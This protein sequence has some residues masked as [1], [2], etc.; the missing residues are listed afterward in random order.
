MNHEAAKLC[1]LKKRRSL[2]PFPARPIGKTTLVRDDGGH[3][4]FPQF[5]TVD[6]MSVKSIRG[7][8]SVGNQSANAVEKPG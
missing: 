7:G 1:P 8:P 6:S 2:T 4:P 5:D 3:V